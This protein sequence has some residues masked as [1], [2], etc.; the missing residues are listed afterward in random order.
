MITKDRFKPFVEECRKVVKERFGE[1]TQKSNSYGRLINER[2]FDTMERLVGEL[3]ESKILIG[4]N[5]DKSDLFFS[6]TVV[7]PLTPNEGDLMSEEIFGPI[8]PIVPVNDMEEAI[9]VI[10]SK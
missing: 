7:G 4:G 5:K 3:D 10:K 8:L 6:P 1:D 9:R 2:R